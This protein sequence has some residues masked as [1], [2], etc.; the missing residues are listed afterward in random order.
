MNTLIKSL[1][2]LFNS[3]NE[4]IA[5]A[6]TGKRITHI[7]L[8]IPFVIVFIIAASVISF[9]P[10]QLIANNFELSK[11]FIAFYNLFVSF[12]FVI[13]LVWLWVKFFEKRSFKSLGFVLNGAFKKYMKGFI[14]GLVML[15]IVLLLIVV[16][17]QVRLEDNPVTFN[18]NVLGTIILLLVGYIVQGAAEEIV[19][20]TFK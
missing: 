10:G 5:L 13:V 20:K 12:G 3:N 6:R 8:A 17:G 18:L 19:P 16:F 7:A 4:F 15:G 11:A 9:I 2:S 14:S 1:K